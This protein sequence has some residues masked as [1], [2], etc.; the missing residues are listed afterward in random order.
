MT[1]KGDGLEKLE[2][3]W[4]N[5]RLMEEESLEIDLGGMNERMRVEGSRS[6]VGKVWVD[7]Q[8][9]KEIMEKTITRV[10]RLSKPGKFKELGHNVFIIS[11]ST[12]A[13][14]ERVMEGSQ[15]LFDNQLFTLKL[16]DGMAKLQEME[17]DS[18]VF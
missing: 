10:W 4:E 7:Q 6:L 2:D 1:G 18:E 5:L 11:F 13:N 9:G 8:I 17:F 14:K 16:F 12:H 3:L 15:W